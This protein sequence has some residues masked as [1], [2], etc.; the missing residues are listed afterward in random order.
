QAAT[1]NEG[2]ADAAARARKLRCGGEGEKLLG[3]GEPGVEPEQLLH[4]LLGVVVCFHA[5]ASG[6]AHLLDQIGAVKQKCNGVSELFAVSV[7]IKEAGD[8]MLDDFPARTQIGGDHG[9][10]PGIGLQNGFPQGL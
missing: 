5:T 3:G 2:D 10:S 9:P 6:S 1:P 4:M 7:G 8:A